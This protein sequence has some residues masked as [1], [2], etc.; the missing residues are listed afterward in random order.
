M[1]ESN[2]WSLLPVNVQFGDEEALQELLE[3]ATGR[4]RN[5]PNTWSA[6]RLHTSSEV[7]YVWAGRR[8]G[9]RR[10]T[11]HRQTGVAPPSSC[12]PRLKNT[13]CSHIR[14]SDSGT[15]SSAHKSLL[16]IEENVLCTPAGP[17]SMTQDCARCGETQRRCS[18]TAVK[19]SS[20]SIFPP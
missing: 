9:S 4:V 14:R 13:N 7:L 17:G 11:I 15:H 18:I 6:F 1:S 8:S 3:P 16:C 12:A 19:R 10:H 20:I 2:L 5:V